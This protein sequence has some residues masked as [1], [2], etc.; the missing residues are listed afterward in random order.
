LGLDKWI[1]PEDE[2]KKP[3][4]TDEITK[5]VKGKAKPKVKISPKKPIDLSKFVLLCPKASCKY[6][7]T[8]MKK[9]LTDK[10]KICPRCQS[11]MKM[12]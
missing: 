9:K 8:L 7:K 3:K 10:D 2:E 12:K 5:E 1:K 6:Q 11:K 4:K